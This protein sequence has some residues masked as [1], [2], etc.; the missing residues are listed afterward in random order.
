[1]INRRQSR[2]RRAADLL[3][4]TLTAPLWVPILVV[5]AAL[6]LVT[7]GRPILFTHDRVGLHGD[8]FAMRKFRS[9]KNGDNPIIPDPDRITAIGRIL[10]RT[11]LDELPQLMNVLEGSMSLVGPRPMLPSQLSSLTAEQRRRL[12]VLP[13][14]TGLAQINGRNA[15]SWDERFD[16]DIAWVDA[17]TLR[18][19]A[20]ILSK[21]ATT[22][23]SGDGVTG[24]DANDPFVLHAV[25]EPQ[26]DLVDKPAN[27]H[28][29]FDSI[30][31]RAA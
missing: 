10:R 13:G 21:T 6:V 22:V 9:M 20:T 19:Y 3:L 7:S 14:L 2:L 1:M 30:T 31:E 28:A 17:P 5:L 12:H 25:D 8:T 24:H 15:L 18:A 11:S 4:V 29:G 23:L 26:I 16:H 27:D